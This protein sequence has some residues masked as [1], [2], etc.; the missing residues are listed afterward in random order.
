MSTAVAANQIAVLTR[1]HSRGEVRNLWSRALTTFTDRPRLPRL[2][3]GVAVAI[4][5]SVFRQPND[6]DLDRCR[7]AHLTDLPPPNRG[8]HESHSSDSYN[9]RTGSDTGLSRRRWSDGT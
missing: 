7:G 4:T 2:R 9:R 8:L 3:F 5:R 6:V 1:N